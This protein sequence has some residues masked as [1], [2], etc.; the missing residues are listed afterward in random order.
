[1]G[2]YDGLP[3]ELQS[4]TWRSAGHY[5]PGTKEAKNVRVW[6]P[7]LNQDFTTD[8]L[9]AS[10]QVANANARNGVN[11]TQID[12]QTAFM[13]GLSAFG[14][15]LVRSLGIMPDESNVQAQPVGYFQRDSGGMD[16]STLLIVAAVGFGVYMA[17]GK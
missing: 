11:T 13:D 1:M 3:Y 9:N 10:V 6:N 4:P 5:R 16:T 15:S 14:S 2:L 12:G 8:I 7:T 17:F